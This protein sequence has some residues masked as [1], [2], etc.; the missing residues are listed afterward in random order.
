MTANMPG[1]PERFYTVSQFGR[2]RAKNKKCAKGMTSQDSATDH[3]A[4][5]VA[6]APDNGDGGYCGPLE[7]GTTSCVP[8]TDQQGTCG[9]EASE[10][11]S[12]GDSDPLGKGTA[13]RGSTIDK[14]A[15]RGHAHDSDPLESDSILRTDS[16][17]VRVDARTVTSSDI[18]Q[19]SAREQVTLERPESMPATM[20][21][22]GFHRCQ[23]RVISL[24]YG[25]CGFIRDCS[26]QYSEYATHCSAV[27]DV[28]DVQ[29]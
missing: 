20:Q 4:T 3:Q 10:N 29:N 8:A 12:T 28:A 13:L 27:Q 23:R 15:T 18:A 25:H 19:V 5:L 17:C 16:G 21:K 6:K 22:A 26:P 7:K 2:K 9:A 11:S 14:Q 24:I 1:G